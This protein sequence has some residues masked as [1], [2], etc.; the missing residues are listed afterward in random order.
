MADTAPERPDPR[1]DQPA[2]RRPGRRQARAARRRRAQA[3]AA[4]LDA[5]IQ[6][7]APASLEE[8]STPFGYLFGDL[9]DEYPSAHLPVEPSSTVVAG[10]KA[11]G[12]AMVDAPPDGD[13]NSTHP[14]RVHVL[15]SVRRPRRHREHRPQRRR[16][17]R[18]R[19]AD[20]DRAGP[21][22]G[23]PAQPPRAAH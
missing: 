12:S 22:A 16:L 6:E 14:A 13:P 17:D 19:P 21:G 4:P 5:V 15:G 20:A 10:L 18:R 7:A 2:P 1:P 9:A 23:H 8:I 3:E 11:L